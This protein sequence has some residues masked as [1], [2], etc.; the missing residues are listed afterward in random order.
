MIKDLQKQESNGGQVLTLSDGSR[1]ILPILNHKRYS[2]AQLDDYMHLTRR[3]FPH[4]SPI[5]FGLEARVSRT[6]PP[7]T[8]GFGLWN[9]PF[10]MGL[11]AGGV[12]RL[13][14]VLPNAAWFF[15]GSDANSLTLR[16]DLPGSGF[17]LKTF[18]SPLLPSVFS[19]FALPLVPLLLVPSAARLLRK[20][21]RKMVKEDARSLAVDVTDWHVYQLIWQ[22][23]AVSFEVDGEIMHQ[24]QISPQGRMGVVIWIDNQY[25]S[26]NSEGNL[27]YGVSRTHSEQYLDIQDLWLRKDIKV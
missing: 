24:T 10:S 26:F 2:L 15:Y 12:K 20:L 6:D 3:R 22:N 16:D 5:S 1:L 14:P 8:W 4:Q 18:R 23:D 11:L 21:L 27:C 9:D 13:L 7:G 25:L 17:H 19:I